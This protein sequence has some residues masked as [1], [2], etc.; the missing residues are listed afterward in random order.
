MR[1]CITVLCLWLTACLGDSTN[2]TATDTGSQLQDNSVAEDVVEVIDDVVP[3]ISSEPADEGPKPPAPEMLGGDRPAKYYLPLGG[4]T[5]EPMPLIVLLHGFSANAYW[6]NFYFGLNVETQKRGMMLITPDGTINPDDK[7]FWNATDSCCNYYQQDVDDVAYITSLIEEAQVYFHIDT[8]RIYLVGHSNGG[9]MSYRVACDRSELIAGIVSLAGT[10]WYDASDCGE[11]SPVSVLQVH[12]DWDA[13]ILYE[14]KE[15]QV[16]NPVAQW[17]P[18]GTCLGTECTESLFGCTSN[19]GC[20]V[21]YTCYGTCFGQ[22]DYFGC[23]NACWEAA[24]PETQFIWWGTYI[25]GLNNG[26]YDDPKMSIPG[27]ASAEESVRRWALRNG[28][29]QIRDNGP[30]MDLVNELP[31]DDTYPLIHA[32]CPEGLGAE[33]WKIEYGS[34]VPGFNE[35]WSPAIVDWLM[36]QKKNAGTE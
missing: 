22:T 5:E 24:T 3:D 21:L 11:P 6:Q 8:D 10:T 20:N 30:V 36:N 14:G 31:G 35:N 17:T 2:L 34:H 18:I 29:D 12:G 27:Y 28:C 19:A 9:Y 16:G 32:N 26:C 13:V 4:A 7:N 33:V 1:L 23:I 25:C 15:K